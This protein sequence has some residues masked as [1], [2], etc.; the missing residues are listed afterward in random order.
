MPDT[1]SCPVHQEPELPMQSV[2][3]DVLLERYARA[4]EQS[5][6]A[7]NRRVAHALAQAESAAERSAWEERFLHTLEAGFLP[8]GRIQS[9]AG[10]GLAATLVNCFVQ[11]VGDSIIHDDEGYPGIY[12]A[13]AEVAE[14]MRRGGGVGCDFSRIRPR[15]AWVAGIEGRASG[16]V[17]FLR[18]FDRSCE[19]VESAG[20][21]RGAQ[22]G[23]LRCDHPDIEAFI[24]AKDSGDLRN[25]NLSVGVSDAFM[26]AVQCDAQIELVHR[27]APQPAAQ[28]AGIERRLQPN[29]SSQWVYGRRSARELWTKIMRSAYERGEPG[30]LFLDTIN[31]DNN[32][33]YCEQLGATNPCGEQPLPPYGSCCLGSIDLTRFVRDAFE[34]SASFDEDAFAAVARVATRM[35]DNVLDVTVWPLRH[36]REQSREKR[37]IGLGFTGLGDALVMLNLRYDSEAAR[38]MARRIATLLRDTAYDASVDLARERGAFTRFDA[39]RFLG[40]EGFASRLPQALRERIREHGLRNSHLLAI[41]PAGTISLAFADNVSNGIEPVYGWQCTRHVCLGEGHVHDHAVEDHAYRVFRR[42]KGDAAELPSAFVTA[43]D[44]DARDHL[45]MVAAV[46]PC[47]DAAISK[48]VNVATDCPFS[49]FETLYLDA[50]RMGIKGLATYR[51]HEGLARVLAPMPLGGG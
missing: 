23:V 24:E 17:S 8:A 36:Q 21:R 31:R 19:T 11:P 14:T 2:S 1:E 22:M 37:R 45:A 34:P 26:K 30:V 38:Q 29:G 50:W 43:L 35:L 44:I 33:A 9:A 27:A 10:C 39:G 47:I 28:C 32:L 46:A 12:C 51:A 20:A 7:V 40:G 5:I 41:A 16:P 3:R 6:G 25:F 18:L 4:G 15:G 48:T 13:L 42:L 49:E